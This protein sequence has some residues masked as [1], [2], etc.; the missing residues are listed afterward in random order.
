MAALL[1]PDNAKLPPTVQLAQILAVALFADRARAI[2]TGFA[3]SGERNDLRPTRW[4]TA[5]TWPDG[6]GASSLLVIQAEER[7]RP[8]V[9]DR[10]VKLNIERPSSKWNRTSSRNFPLVVHFFRRFPHHRVR[11]RR[12]FTRNRM[13]TR[14]FLWWG[15]MLRRDGGMPMT[16]RQDRRYHPPNA[17]NLLHILEH[18]RLTIMSIMAD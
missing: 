1:L 4:V 5:R 6:R 13:G 3:P 15:V 17:Q 18:D 7:L 11:N 2:Q 8:L 12:I 16:L 14:R 10:I 9:Y